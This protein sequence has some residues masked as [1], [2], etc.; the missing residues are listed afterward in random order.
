MRRL[1]IGIIG[2]VALAFALS[3]PA[4]ADYAVLRNADG[5]C[6]IV[7]VQPVPPH[8]PRLRVNW[9]IIAI[10]DNWFSAVFEREWAWTTGD[11]KPLY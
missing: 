7:W 5:Y 2:I 8:A 3:L 6:D 4:R 9:T 1:S 11:C 10:I